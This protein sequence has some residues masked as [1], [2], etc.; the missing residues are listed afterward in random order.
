LLLAKITGATENVLLM[1][2]VPSAGGFALTTVFS[3]IRPN[4][5]TACSV[6]QALC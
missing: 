6:E 2:W 3:I 4:N 1:N 5:I